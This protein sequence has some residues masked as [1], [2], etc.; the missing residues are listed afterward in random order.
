MC[1]VVSIKLTFF[2]QADMGQLYVFKYR[3]GVL[4]VLPGSGALCVSQF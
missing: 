1:Q 3:F 4:L 2:L